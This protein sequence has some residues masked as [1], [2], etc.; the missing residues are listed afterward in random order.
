MNRPSV[1]VGLNPGGVESA[2]AGR[3]MLGRRKSPRRQ[4]LAAERE[5]LNEAQCKQSDR[6]CDA[7]VDVGP[8]TGRS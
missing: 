6:C 4:L 2:L 3:R 5:A 7:Q 1:A 8:A